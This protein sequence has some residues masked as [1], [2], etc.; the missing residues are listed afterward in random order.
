M[1]LLNEESVYTSQALA[2]I[3]DGV[4][5]VKVWQ[6]I[7]SKDSSIEPSNEQVGRLVHRSTRDLPVILRE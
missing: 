1:W 2:V 5:R 6:L 4:N 3:P 7:Q